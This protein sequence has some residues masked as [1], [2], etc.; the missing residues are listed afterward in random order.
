MKALSQKFKVRA[1]VWILAI[2][3]HVAAAA[4]VVFVKPVREFLFGGGPEENLLVVS[5]SRLQEILGEMLELNR[6]KFARS[7]QSLATNYQGMAAIRDRQLSKL[8]TARNAAIA[9][10]APLHPLPAPGALAGLGYAELYAAATNIEASI[11]ELYKQVRAIRMATVRSEL[12]FQEAL[13][14]TTVMSPSRVAL[15][16]EVF[17]LP[18]PR[19]ESAR[20]DRFRLE[21]KR[22]GKEMGAVTAYCAKLLEF[23]TDIDQDSD[24]MTLNLFME[25]NDIYGGGY[26][27]PTLMPN[28]IFDTHEFSMGSFQSLTGRKLIGQGEPG[29]WLYMDSWYIVGPFP[30]ERRRA[31]DTRFGPEAGVDLDARYVGKGGREIKW[32]YHRSNSLKI[33]PRVVMSYSIYYAFTE[34]YSDREREVWL[35]TGTDDH[36]KI[37][38]NDEHIWTSP[39]DP[40]PFKADEH[41][42]MVKLRKGFNEILVRCENAGGTMGFCLLF[43]TAE[44]E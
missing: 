22:G 30:N 5:E 33:E 20:I 34:I 1:E 7:A 28:E 39:M 32:E 10:P 35:S 43:C 15:P 11:V 25:N 14:S 29:M 21:L 13:D 12:T 24:G 27:G 42:Q 16:A 17:A 36:G 26:V 3:L 38:I 23:A 9:L 19:A 41:V 31:M 2:V 40:K 4:V 6:Q 37:W 8:A 18:I 44:T